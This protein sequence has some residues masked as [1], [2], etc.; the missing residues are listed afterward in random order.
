MECPLISVVVPVYNIGEYVEKCLKSL[1]TQSYENIEV[2]VVDDGSTDGSGEICDKIATSDERI[3]VFHKKNGG[4]SDARNYGIKKA[5]GTIVA[6]IDGDDYVRKDYIKTMHAEMKKTDAGIVICGYNDV[7]PE[8]V[9]MSGE[10]AAARLLVRQENLEIVAWNKLYRKSL[11]D[12]IKY[13]VGEVN[14]DSLTTYKLLAEAKKVA[15]VDKTLYVYVERSDSTMATEKVERRLK[16]REKAA[17][18]AMEYF[19]KNK[20][21]KDAAGVSLLTAKYAFVDAAIKGEIS[22]SFYDKN[23]QWINGHK[24]IYK[25]NPFVNK[26]LKLYMILCSLGLYRV[27]RKVV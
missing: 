7:V 13:P 17:K 19:D 2:I 6:L 8:K 21:L 10:D 24:N 12:R 14:E 3:R 23:V 4:L 27:F 9:L 26:K 20:K 15:Y 5:R 22:K 1:I 18:E 11:F 25:D 16:N